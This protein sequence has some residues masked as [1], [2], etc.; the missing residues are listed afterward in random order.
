MRKRFVFCLVWMLLLPTVCAGAASKA[1]YTLPLKAITVLQNSPDRDIVPQTEGTFHPVIAGESPVTGLPWEG[2]YMPML[3][4]IGSNIGTVKHNSA[5]VKAVGIGKAAPWGIQYADIVYESAMT[6]TGATRFTALFSDCFA[7][8]QPQTGVGPVRSARLAQLYL[9]D[10][11]QC[12]LV[13]SG[14]FMGAF[15][16]GD[17][18]SATYFEETGVLEQG[19]LM[20]ML[21]GRLRDYRN[22]VQAIKAPSNLNVD[23]VGLRKLIPATS[24]AQPRPFL[25]A[26]Q[27]HYTDGYTLADTIHLDWGEKSSISHFVYDAN[28]HCYRRFCGA[29]IKAD[30][31]APFTAFATA[32][33]R[34]EEAVQTLEFANLIVQRVSF[35]QGDESLYRPELVCVGK[36]NADI[37]IGG[38]SIPGYWVRTSVA[39]PTVY[40]DDHGNELVLSRGKTFIALMPTESLC[41]FSSAE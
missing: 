21:S 22:R 40:Y 37:F 32:E 12:G 20:N 34:S 33:D 4:Q 41:A 19:V 6:R 26:N 11:W 14:G 2:D 36:G 5:T 16:W 29:G 23:I 27:S 31:W 9:R 38:R 10:E 13:Y 28:N 18:K 1:V 24:V 30:K 15:S 3:V 35:E 8:G 39:E 25:F 17:P 7:Q